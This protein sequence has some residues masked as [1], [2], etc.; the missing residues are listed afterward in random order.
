M[1]THGF[2]LLT[3]HCLKE[4]GGMARLWRHNATDALL[5]SITN[6]DENKC[7]GVS[8]RTPP[9]DSTG[10]AHILEHSVLCGSKKYPV[11]E[12]FVELLKGSL[13]TFLNAFTFPD[14][15]CYPVASTNLQDFYNLIDVY[16]DAVFHPRISKDIFRQEGWHIEAES[17]DGPWT[18]KGV[19]YNEMK[20]A[21][22]SPDSVLAE[23]SQQA[24]F[25]DTLYSLDSGGNPEHIPNLT[26]EAFYNFHRHYYH[27]C[28]AR[29]FFWGDDPEEKR[30]RRISLELEGYAKKNADSAVPL[31]E[32][33]ALPRRVEKT[34][35][36]AE[37]EKR[38]LFT[39]NWLLDERDDM[40]ETLRMEMLEH[41]LEGMP[42]SP[43]RKALI[44]SGL[45]EDTTGCGLE[46]D[47]RQMY[48]STGLKGVTIENV[49]K[50]E[51]LIF[52]TLRRLAEDGIAPSAVE[53][54]VNS[55]EF[56][57][58][59]N[60][61]GRFPRGLAAMIRSLSTWLY[62]GDP[63][64]PLAW[65]KPL[66][67]IK[68]CLAKG[69][70]IFERLLQEHFLNNTHRT[71]VVLTPD[72]NLGNTREQQEKARLDA[73]YSQSD[74]QRRSAIVEQTRR[75]QQTQTET[76]SPEALATI[77]NLTPDDLPRENAPIPRRVTQGT[78]VFLSHE[79]P[80]NGIAYISLLLPIRRLPDNLVP[81]LPV[82]VR[83]LTELGT[84]RHDFT[85]FGELVAAKT[86]GV[87]A[88]HLT[89][90]TFGKRGIINYLS[91]SGKAVYEKIPDLFQILQEI[92]LE[93]LNDPAAATERLQQ[94]LLEEKARL[95]YV[96]QAAGNATVSLRLRARFTGADA[97]AE[98]TCGLT[99]LNSVRYL[100]KQLKTRPETLLG[101]LETLRS[102]LLAR[103]GAIFDCTAE[104]C[105][106]ARAE[107]EAR[108]LLA[109]LPEGEEGDS[110]PPQ[111]MSLPEAEAFLAPV[112]I[113]YV[114]KAANIYDQ[115]YSYHGS[116]SV[117]LRYL[118]MGRLW[119]QVRVRGGAY[120]TSCRLDRLS[121][122]L[123]CSSYR[124]PNVDQTLAAF[125]GMAD[126]LRSVTPDAEQL[127]RAIVG[128][129]GDMDAYLLPDAKGALSLLRWLTRDSDETRQ[130]IREEMF[131]VTPRHFRAFADVLAEVAK[132][133]AV[134][135][136]GGRQAKETAQTR[137]WTVQ[138]L[139]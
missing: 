108:A 14:K 135:V 99:Y 85:Q 97:L 132:K 33:K 102:L 5:L 95:E 117:I 46:T 65:E 53:A 30:L 120:G 1:R 66:A 54:A 98:R 131:A 124:D 12:P 58:R 40:D 32:H 63:L 15:T 7:F 56:A 122:T 36:A 93:H 11:R 83:S 112:M 88:N 133:G 28:N 116:A 64:T 9:S 94:M 118:R 23:Q 20:G 109:A 13:Q 19:V 3:E 76:D 10:V 110:L 89:G 84:A 134:C 37:G 113:N 61:S 8:F 104:G 103:A 79:L 125:D 51:D 44:G 57:Y 75:L 114:G 34:Y 86:G 50:A 121:G 60:N 100:L 123:V 71:T 42:G 78:H 16:L 41:I 27:P 39:V 24:L 70:N 96:L 136:L 105:G 59:E 72:E 126:F 25:P 47:L 52:D 29:F 87:G 92:L 91:I 137:G 101:D 6:T 26:Y 4:A 67:A 138:K 38:A 129:I 45:G 21:Y 55:V 17:P 115:G 77:P 119:E 22:S 2:R 107:N 106:I 80:T 43:L 128:A 130:Q 68:D 62:D 90:V 74:T 31:Q 111:P 69:E 49:Q 35:A 73:I 82:F 139:L 127:S 81:L 18:F 48:Y